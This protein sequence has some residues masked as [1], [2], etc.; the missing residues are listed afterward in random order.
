MS[1]LEAIIPIALAG[2]SAATGL[3]Q[4]AKRDKSVCHS[5]PRHFPNQTKAKAERVF[6]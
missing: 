3:A 2:V 6:L 1:G 5:Q 4:L